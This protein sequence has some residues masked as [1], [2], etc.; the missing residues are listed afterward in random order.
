M[1]NSSS[2]LGTPLGYIVVWAVSAA[3]TGA[4]AARK[5]RSTLM[6]AIGGVF[7]PGTA[8]LPL[9]FMSYLCPKCQRP[10]SYDEWKQKECPRCRGI[11][12]GHKDSEC[13]DFLECPS[14]QTMIPPG[15]P[16]CPK[17]GWS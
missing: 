2:V 16:K 1:H 17:C 12:P 6:W 4:L 9:L 13:K 11:Q 5:N 3:I 8:L 14:C 10:V 7:C 15:E